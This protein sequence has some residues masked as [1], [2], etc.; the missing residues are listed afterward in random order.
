MKISDLVN[1]L[2]EIRS[3]HGDLVVNVCMNGYYNG[4][5]PHIDNSDEDMKVNVEE[6]NLYFADGNYNERRLVCMIDGHSDD[7][8]NSGEW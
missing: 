6:C 1:Q 3:R 5:E 2:E 4:D 8:A 7:L